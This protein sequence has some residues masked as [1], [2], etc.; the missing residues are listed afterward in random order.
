MTYEQYTHGN[1]ADRSAQQIQSDLGEIRSEI[2]HTLDALSQQLAPNQLIAHAFDAVKRGGGGEIARNLSRSVKENPLPLA[3]IAAGFGYLMYTDSQRRRSTQT[4]SFSNGPQ[5]R[6]GEGEFDFEPIG[7]YSKEEGAREGAD[8]K[9]RLSDGAERVR[10]GARDLKHQA[11]DKFGQVKEQV[12]DGRQWAGDK[13]HQVSDQ[14]RAAKAWSQDL[15]EEQPLV[16]AGLGLAFGAAAAALVPMSRKEHE[17]MGGTGRQLRS[18][19]KELAHEVEGKAKA[20]GSSAASAAEEAAKQEA[21]TQGVSLQ[22]GKQPSPQEQ[23]AQDSGKENESKTGEP[24]KRTEQYRATYAPGD[25]VSP[26]I[27]QGSSQAGGARPRE[28]TLTYGPGT[29]PGSAGQ[30][31]P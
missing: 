1:G 26:G 9:E 10:Q 20:I 25:A 24:P 4:Q 31:K 3:M 23:H 15:I 28:A 21:E 19:A 13:A 8:V 11:Q 14:A 22:S 5:A 29:L 6:S 17:V 12:H 18:Q 7:L 2:D 27:V 16:L 30:K